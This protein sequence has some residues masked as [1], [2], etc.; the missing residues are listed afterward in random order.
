MV[1]SE[2]P[3]LFDGARGAWESTLMD[4]EGKTVKRLDRSNVSNKMTVLA[5][6][7]AKTGL[8]GDDGKGMTSTTATQAWLVIRCQQQRDKLVIRRRKQQYNDNCGSNGG[9]ANI[10]WIGGNGKT[11]RR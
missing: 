7:T 1:E 5:T 3:V 4:L 6:T 8:G 11:A 9:D 10:A 2:E